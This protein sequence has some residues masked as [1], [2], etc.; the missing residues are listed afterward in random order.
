MKVFCDTPVIVPKADYLEAIALVA[1]AGL[2]RGAVYDALHVVAA[3]NSR[4]FV[5]TA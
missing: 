1:R 4:S 5:I 2:T 3:T